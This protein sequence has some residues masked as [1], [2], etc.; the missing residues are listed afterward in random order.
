M[1]VSILTFEEAIADSRKVKGS[2]HLLLGNGFSIAC[3]P[4]AFRYARLV[5]EADFSRLSV[6]AQA[7][8]A[9]SG[10]SDFE[11]VIEALRTTAMTTALYEGREAPLLDR[12]VGDRDV[13]R[14]ALARV[15]SDR[16]PDNVGA[17]APKEY[18]SARRFVAHFDGKLYT[19]SYDLLLYW[20]LL[21]D[22]E[23]SIRTDDG[24]RADPDDPDADWVTWDGFAGHDQRVFHLHGGLHL[25][26]AG[27]YLKK[28]TWSRSGIALVDQIRAALSTAIYPLVVTEGSTAEKLARIEHSPYLH[29]GLKSM[30]QCG[31][32]LFIYGHSLDDND[33][34]VMRR[35]E[36]GGFATAYVSLYGNPE[37]ESNVRIRHR[38]RLMVDRRSVHEESKSAHLRKPL[39][40]EFFDAETAHVWT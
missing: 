31:G 6:D 30:T 20:T 28:L 13:L 3:R 19:V 17:I 25:Y 4:E 32:S 33:A 29:R 10:T 34:H 2:R 7:L 26:D 12:L 21:Q 35:I 15:L 8:F 18:A 27:S 22:L 14:E 11:R 39:R 9:L 23:P 5:D 1:A 40:V 36:D 24:F 38:A 37:D 16:H